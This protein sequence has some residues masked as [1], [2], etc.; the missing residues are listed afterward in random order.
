VRFGGNTAC[1]EVRAA[2]NHVVVLDAGSG[3][4]R[5]GMTI[6]ERV[7]RIDILLSHLH[8]DHILGLGFFEPLFRAGTEVHIWGPSSNVLDIRARLTRYL[9]QPL[10]PVR[11]HDL[12]CEPELHDVP[13]GRFAVP[14][15]SVTAMLVC[16]PAPTVGYRL[17][18]GRSVLAY[19]PDHEPAL[20]GFPAPPEW[21][22]GYDLARD[23]DLLI[24]DAQYT[25][26]EYPEHVGWGHSAI[27]HTLAFAHAVGTA[28]LVPFHHDPGHSDSD[29]DEMYAGLALDG[30]DVTPAVEGATFEL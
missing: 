23:A 6:D 19:L 12:P 28:H 17:D 11:V 7:E 14:G 25:D 1:V 20:A 15:L 4:R 22:S 13:L 10:F 16:H 2:E 29:L 18:D 3:I 24:H 5:L 27:S 30:L 21:T 9:S 8:L 26:E